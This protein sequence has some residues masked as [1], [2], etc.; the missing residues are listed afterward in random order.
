MA[1]DTIGFA[2]ID[3]KM[4]PEMSGKNASLGERFRNLATEGIRIPDGFATRVPGFRRHC[5]NRRAW[6]ASWI[7]NFEYAENAIRSLSAAYRRHRLMEDFPSIS[8]VDMNPVF[9]LENEALVGNARIFLE[10]G[11]G[12]ENP[13]PDII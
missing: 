10:T 1:R 2:N 6:N 9:A 11:A 12:P 4:L 3:L 5:K 13:Y 8:E 7:P